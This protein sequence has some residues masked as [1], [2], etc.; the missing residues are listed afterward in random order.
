[1]SPFS[2]TDTRL[3]IEL[4]QDHW[5]GLHQVIDS[6]RGQINLGSI[7]QPRRLSSIN[8]RR[9]L[10]LKSHL[11]VI[12]CSNESHY[13]RTNFISLQQAPLHNKYTVIRT[14]VNVPYLILHIAHRTNTFPSVCICAELR[15]NVCT[16]V[17][18]LG[19][20]VSVSDTWCIINDM[21]VCPYCNKT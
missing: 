9:A 19:N 6:S 2:D 3:R 20:C 16:Y 14:Y 21:Y 18:I 15:I 7:V 8:R 12:P 10:Q 5:V 4:V 17:R 1:M 11:V 13:S